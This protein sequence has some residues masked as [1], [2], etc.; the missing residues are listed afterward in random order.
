MTPAAHADAAPVPF[1]GTLTFKR[2]LALH[3]A[4]RPRWAH[5]L[6]TVACVA[7]LLIRWNGVVDWDDPDAPA[8]LTVNTLLACIVGLA[9]W[10]GIRRLP[11][12]HWRRMPD[13]HGAA[14]GTAGADGVRWQTATVE[15][16]YSWDR[17]ARA[18]EADGMVL[19]VCAPRGALYFPREFFTDEASWNAFRSIVRTYARRA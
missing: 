2:F 18:R 4:L 8:R 9:L 17:I 7:W 12:R 16:R 11:R 13:L 15:S 6:V 5:P 1:G 19:L 10:A 3:D 14:T